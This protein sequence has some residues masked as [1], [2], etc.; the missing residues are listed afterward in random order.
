MGTSTRKQREIREREELILDV[1]AKMLVERGFN[2]L[3]MDR[4][5]EAI[6]YSKGTVYQHF[7]CKEDLLATLTV[8]NTE[9]RCD[10]FA[11]AIEF[12][13]TT[14]E[15]MTAIG[16]AFDVLMTLHPERCKAET[17]YHASHMR[18]KASEVS[19]AE[20]KAADQRCDDLLGNLIREAIEAGDLPLRDEAT[21][22]A[23]HFGLWALSWGSYQI[24]ETMEPCE[25]VERGFADPV[26]AL[27][28]NQERLLDGFGW[29]PLSSEKD[30]PSV[31]H[32]VRDQLFA[33]EQ[34]QI[35]QR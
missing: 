1:A 30:Y 20:L 28:M 19:K 17:L 29:T 15:R 35:E 21:L 10:L 24:V 27:H 23:L 18:A 8:R 7:S 25:L 9:L 2:Y 11:R 5:A 6:E 4:I 12:K 26:A 31:R 22:H 3:T 32:R 13:G 16:A 14:R 34:R 33:Q